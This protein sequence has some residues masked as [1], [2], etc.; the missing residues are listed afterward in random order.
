MKITA[1]LDDGSKHFIRRLNGFGRRFKSEVIQATDTIGHALVNWTRETIMEQNFAP[2]NEQYK[3][4]KGSHGYSE[5]ILIMTWQMYR[6]ISYK[7]MATSGSMVQGQVGFRQSSN[8]RAWRSYARYPDKQKMKNR[9][10]KSSGSIPMAELGKWLEGYN[11]DTSRFVKK[12]PFFE[13]TLRKHVKDIVAAY[14][15][16]FAR[17]FG[18]IWD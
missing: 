4:W 14:A 17:A 12:R 6:S 10:G 15:A 5:L 18:G 3:A 11:S 16:A 7:R 2:L 13:P 1:K 9:I 8:H